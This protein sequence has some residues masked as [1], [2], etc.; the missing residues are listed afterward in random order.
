VLEVVPTPELPVL[1]AGQGGQEG[2]QAAAVE[3]GVVT[4]HGQA[5][6]LRPDDDAQRRL[7]GQVEAAE[8]GGGVQRVAVGD[9]GVGGRTRVP[10]LAAEPGPG[11]GD[12]QV[13]GCQPV[14]DPV[15]GPGQGGRGHHDPGRPPVGEPQQGELVG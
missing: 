15:G 7:D 11:H 8:Q 1:T 9:Q 4:G 5:A 2:D 3:G 6:A 13:Q 14:V 12:R 10:D